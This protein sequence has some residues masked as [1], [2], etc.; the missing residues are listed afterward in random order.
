MKGVIKGDVLSYRILHNKL[1]VKSPLYGWIKIED[2][3][4]LVS[5]FSTIYPTHREAKKRGYEAHHVTPKS[6]QKEIYGSVQD[7]SCVRVTP[8][9]HL[10]LHWFLSLESEEG[11]RMFHYLA[12]GKILLMSE[13][14]RR[15]IYQ[16]CGSQ[17]KDTYEDYLLTFGLT[18]RRY[19]ETL[20]DEEFIAYVDMMSVMDRDELLKWLSS[21]YK[22]L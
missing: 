5:A 2:Y 13:E 14:E 7:D 10:V 15:F 1:F 19:L 21:P 6:C 16:L 4:T 3:C 17:W 8:F 20:T 9:E 11:E 22:K 12:L 18:G